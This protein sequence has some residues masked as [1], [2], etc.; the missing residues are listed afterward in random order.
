MRSVYFHLSAR[1][2]LHRSVM[3]SSMV[4]LIGQACR[5]SWS[6]VE[7]LLRTTAR[8]QPVRRG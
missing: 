6:L 5:S 4:P 7:G 2:M 1:G 8:V 3:E